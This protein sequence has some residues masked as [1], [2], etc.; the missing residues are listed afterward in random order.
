MEKQRFFRL[1]IFALSISGMIFWLK[2]LNEKGEKLGGKIVSGQ[3]EN[4][5]E[6]VKD[7]P[8]EKILGT[9][10]NIIP[11]FKKTVSELP[12]T[13]EIEIEKKVQEIIEEIK[14]LPKTQVNELK[15]AVFCDEFC[16]TTC[17]EV[18]EEN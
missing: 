10:E 6:E 1:A 13:K 15:K 12:E 17:Q 3:I 16:E 18:C 11:G 2:G 8:G 14:S 9:V 7:F 4:I 5:L